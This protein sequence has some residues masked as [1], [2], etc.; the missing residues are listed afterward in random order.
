MAQCK[1]TL[2]QAENV[3]WVNCSEEIT[4]IAVPIHL[5]SET[6]LLYIYRRKGRH[7]HKT[8]D[9]TMRTE[10]RWMTNLFYLLPPLWSS[11]QSS[12][13]QIQRSRFDSWHYQIFWEVVGL[14]WG[15]LSLVSTIEVLLERKSS[16]SSLES[17]N[18]G[19]RDPPHWQLDTCVRAHMHFCVC[20]CVRAHKRT[21]CIINYLRS[22]LYS[23]KKLYT[24]FWSKYT[25]LIF[26]WKFLSESRIM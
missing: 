5:F 16:G 24:K 3:N 14:E 11:S 18:Y 1:G 8:E 12:W 19:R 15:P 20:A 10:Y 13:L 2:P 26:F 23:P 7:V 21:D 4:Y 25:E 6:W 17:Q 22:S 9:M